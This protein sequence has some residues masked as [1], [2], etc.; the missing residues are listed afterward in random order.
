ME[1]KNLKQTEIDGQTIYLKKGF[2]GW[3][4]IYP[5]KIDGKIVWKNFIAGGNWWNLLFLAIA[6]GVILG[7]IYEYSIVL[8][9]L[10]ECMANSNLW[11]IIP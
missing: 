1:V 5:S 8:K 2:F 7:C 11:K 6:I 4:V 9:S 3:N 10:N